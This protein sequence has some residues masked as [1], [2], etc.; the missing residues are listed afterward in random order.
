MKKNDK[1]PILGQNLARGD[2][3]S[4]IAYE[5]ALQSFNNRSR[6]DGDILCNEGHRSAASF[7]TVVSFNPDIKIGITADGI[8]TKIEVAE[9]FKRYDTLGF[10][11]VAMVVDDLVAN[12]IEPTNLSNILDV[13]VLD[14]VVID[15]LMKGLYKAANVAKIAVVGGEIAELGTRVSGYGE[16][17]HFNWSATA[18]GKLVSNHI[19]DGKEIVAGDQIITLKEK[20]LRSNGFTLARDILTKSFGHDWHKEWGEELL[21]PSTIYAHLIIKL[22]KENFPIKGISHITGGSFQNKLGRVLKRTQELSAEL[23]DL[24]PPP[25][26]VLKL[27]QLGDISDYRAY[28]HWNMGNGMLLVVDKKRAIEIVDRI[29]ADEEFEGTRPIAQIAGEITA[30]KNNQ[31]RKIVIHSKATKRDIF[32]YEY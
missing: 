10:D 22:I 12:G 11:L 3:C 31:K 13:D 16:G 25:D 18:I 26:M 21:I 14:Q 20:G 6:S 2:S 15:E 29:N 32:I 28:Q 19:I 30:D 27:Q 24:F 17:M 7:S 23:S 9:R 8:G 5:W 4:K 1:I